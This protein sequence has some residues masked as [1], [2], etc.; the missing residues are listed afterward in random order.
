MVTEQ[1][2]HKTDNTLELQPS[3]LATLTAEALKDHCHLSCTPKS[4]DPLFSSLSSAYG[5]LP[6]HLLVL[7]G[8]L[9]Q[10]APQPLMQVQVLCNAAVKANSLTFGELCLFVVGGHTLPVTCVGHSATKHK[11]EIGVLEDNNIESKLYYP[12]REKHV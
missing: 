9:G 11:G 6:H 5:S 8:E 4:S 7:Y 10:L 1:N 12:L 3:W 2:E